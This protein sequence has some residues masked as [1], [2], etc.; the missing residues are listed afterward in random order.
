MNTN[1]ARTSCKIETPISMSPHVESMP[2]I[3]WRQVYM[4]KL[5]S[6]Y[7]LHHFKIFNSLAILHEIPS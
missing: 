3:D 6:K 5:M 2:S 7:D 4:A 1:T